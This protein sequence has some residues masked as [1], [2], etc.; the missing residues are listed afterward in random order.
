MGDLETFLRSSL[1]NSVPPARRNGREW[2]PW[3]AARLRREKWAGG[4]LWPL[5]F[6][7]MCKCWKAVP[8]Y[9]ST[10]T[11]MFHL[12]SAGVTCSCSFAVDGGLTQPG[13]FCPP[14][15]KNSIYYESVS[16]RGVDL[17]QGEE[18]C[19]KRTHWNWNKDWTQI[20]TILDSLVSLQSFVQ[21]LLSL[22]WL[23]EDFSS[24]GLK[25]SWT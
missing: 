18:I 22:S 20:Q 23:S 8:C 12:A 19:N 13:S 7:P 21:F 16:L 24:S 11:S 1:P 3:T 15:F 4:N 17:G 9:V 5:G 10:Y 6:S 2:V 14:F 25:P